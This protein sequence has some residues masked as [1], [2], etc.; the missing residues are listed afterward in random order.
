MDLGSPIATQSPVTPSLNP[1]QQTNIVGLEPAVFKFAPEGEQLLYYSVL[2]PNRWDEA[3]GIAVQTDFK[4]LLWT[5][6][7]TELTPDGK[8]LVYSTFLGGANFDIASGLALDS[9]GNAYVDGVT[10][11][12]D[13]PVR[14]S[15]QPA[16]GG[17]TDGFLAEIS[18]N[19][20]IQGVPFL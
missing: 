9:L 5:S 4:A 12:V 19:T 15:F 16:Y 1:F 3:L 17:G 20:P 7:M 6:F 2:G 14:N 8:S 10:G 11:S 13:F 18:D